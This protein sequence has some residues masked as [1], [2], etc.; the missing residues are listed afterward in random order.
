MVDGYARETYICEC[1]CGRGFT[2]TKVSLRKNPAVRCK[3]CAGV[4]NALARGDDGRTNTPEWKVWHSMLQRCGQPS[5]QAYERYGARGITVC[6]RWRKFENFIADMGPRPEGM[7][8]E[9]TNNNKGY[10]PTNCVWATPTQQNR[11]TRTNHWLTVKGERMLL[12]DWARRLG[13][14]PTTIWLR[15]ER[16]GW[17]V[18][19]ACTTPVAPRGS[20]KWRNPAKK[21]GD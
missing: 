8:L 3:V 4:A 6:K 2:Q 20:H 12:I 18:E 14:A 21:G 15:I 10:S 13:T 19:D 7:T 1:S 5:A 17:S 11:N 16:Y 9:R